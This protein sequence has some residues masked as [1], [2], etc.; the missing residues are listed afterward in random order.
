MDPPSLVGTRV[1]SLLFLQT[2]LL[3]KRYR[4]TACCPLAPN[5]RG[6]GEYRPIHNLSSRIARM[7]Q[8]ILG[9]LWRMNRPRER[10]SQQRAPPLPVIMGY[11]GMFSSPQIDH[12]VANVSKTSR[13]WQS[14][15]CRGPVQSSTCTHC[16]T[17][18]QRGRDDDARDHTA[19]PQ[20][21]HS[22]IVWSCMVDYFHSPV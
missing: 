8:Q 22:G 5:R 18:R 1:I 3:P 16:F 11:T 15:R 2:P 20:S 10:A 9:N 14:G 12:R 17:H 13:Q 4:I 7:R 19:S 21:I 6:T